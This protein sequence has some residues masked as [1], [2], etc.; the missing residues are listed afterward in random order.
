MQG[1]H[2][3]VQ[4][5]RMKCTDQQEKKLV[6]SRFLKTNFALLT[7]LWNRH[8]RCS[9]RFWISM[10]LW[11]EWYCHALE[12]E[13]CMHRKSHETCLVHTHKKSWCFFLDT[14]ARTHQQRSMKTTCNPC[15]D[16]KRHVKNHDEEDL[17]CSKILI[18]K[19]FLLSE[20]T[21]YTGIGLQCVCMHAHILEYIHTCTHGTCIHA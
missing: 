1:K 18:W 13:S 6:L 5:F 14:R 19:S 2:Q 21:P 4:N 9:H 17:L 16:R 3:S 8:E 12:Y 15:L 20:H 10:H 7:C 11:M